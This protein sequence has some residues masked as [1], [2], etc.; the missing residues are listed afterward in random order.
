MSAKKFNSVHHHFPIFHRPK[1]MMRHTCIECG[2]SF[3]VEWGQ[4][5]SA[6]AK[7]P[8]KHE[9]KAKGKQTDFTPSDFMPR[10]R[11]LEYVPEV[12]GC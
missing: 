9:H 7:C 5:E 11:D 12:A 4:K 1:E 10:P 8:F 6:P 3:F 2:R